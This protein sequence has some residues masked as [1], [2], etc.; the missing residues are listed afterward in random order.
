MINQ[1]FVEIF[2]TIILALNLFDYKRDQNL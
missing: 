1:F 2:S